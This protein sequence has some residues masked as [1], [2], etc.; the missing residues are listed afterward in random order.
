MT[1]VL[2]VDDEPGCRDYL[3]THL[4]HPGRELL[5][6]PGSRQAIDLGVK[7]RPDVLVADWL[8]RDGYNGLHVSDALRAVSPRLRTILITGFASA[9][10]RADARRAGV[11][12]VLEKPFTLEQIEQALHSQAEGRP[13]DGVRPPLAI[14]LIDA[15]R[16]ILHVTPHARE[17]LAASAAG[18]RAESFA[19]FFAPGDAVDLSRAASHWIAARPIAEV[20]VTWALRTRSLG[21]D[22][23]WLIV[24]H[25]PGE[26]QV[27]KD[28]RVRLLLDL[29][30]PTEP[31]WPLDGS[32]VVL[33]RAPASRARIAEAL[34][35]VGCPCHR[36][37][38]EAFAADLLSRDAAAQVVIVNVDS[39]RDPA[40]LAASIRRL[41]HVR[42]GLT[43][44]VACPTELRARLAATGIHVFLPPSWSV[45]DLVKN[46]TGRIGSCV[47]CGLPIPL[48]RPRR[49]ESPVNWECCGCGAR[50]SAVMDDDFP[51][52][53]LASVRLISTQGGG[54]AI[55]PPS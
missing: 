19:Q 46:L 15:A 51:A 17:L 18:P 33:D 41:Q 39:P 37:A 28:A 14:L 1:K 24:M 40:A 11:S 8:L 55:V 50:Y 6:A 32:A 34:E 29:V 44:I 38:D 35:A 23:G 20:P 49:G 25:T 7:F 9:D 43:V 54:R 53:V 16:R 27:E 12:C 36:A 10:V 47:D 5:A 26:Q 21:D 22:D 13:E 3:Q 31:R 48:R 45:H 42:P 2:I 4:M 52:H 30:D